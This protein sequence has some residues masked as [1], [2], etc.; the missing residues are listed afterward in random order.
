MMEAIIMKIRNLLPICTA[1]LLALPAWSASSAATRGR[2]YDLAFNATATERDA[3]R[4]GSYS[5]DGLDWMAQ[6]NQLMVLRGEVNT[7]RRE[8]NHLQS[9]PALPATERRL[10]RRVAH[11]ANLL[12]NDTQNAILFGRNHR[13]ELSNPFYARSVFLIQVNALRLSRDAGAARRLANGN[14]G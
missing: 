3:G 14:E 11:R 8:V 10:L 9:E 7:I 2:L 6:G 4:L 1:A 12:A 13:D 5:A